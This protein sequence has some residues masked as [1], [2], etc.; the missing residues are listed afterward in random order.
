MHNAPA[1][2]YPAGRSRLAGAVMLAAWLAG[3]AG[4]A[5]WASQVQAAA[6][7]FAAVW[8]A[9]VAVGGIAWRGWLRSPVG[10]LTWDGESWSWSA[11]AITQAGMPEVALDA[12]RLLLLR[13]NAPAGRTSWLW[14]ERAGL[15]ARWDDLRRAVYSRASPQALPGAQRP[16]EAKP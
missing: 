4:L 8:C 14:L 13:W 9:A 2:S 1:V 10:T 11:G 16:G 15:P 6:A 5:M 12:Q 3:V 7:A